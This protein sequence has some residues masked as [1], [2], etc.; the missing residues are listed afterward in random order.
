MTRGAGL[1]AW[2]GA[3]RVASCPGSWRGVGRGLSSCAALRAVQ[4]PGAASGAARR[5][6][7]S[8]LLH[9]IFKTVFLFILCQRPGNGSGPQRIRPEK[10]AALAMDPAR[11]GSGPNSLPPWQWIRPVFNRR[12]ARRIYTGQRAQKKKSFY[13]KKEKTGAAFFAK[14]FFCLLQKKE[15][16]RPPG[17]ENKRK[18]HFQKNT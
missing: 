17:V 14:K 11:N 4:D 18:N 9:N 10:A 1:R 6:A 8:F 12:R 5:L 7:V 16:K 13:I 3:L 2:R 15:Q